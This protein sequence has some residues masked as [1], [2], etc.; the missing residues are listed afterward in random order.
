MKRIDINDK[1]Y[2]NPI[3]LYFSRL[4][5][6]YISKLSEEDKKI[7]ELELKLYLLLKG[8]LIVAASDLFTES[9]AE[10]FKDKEI[11]LEEGLIVPALRDKF[12]NIDDF[13]Q[14][15]YN[16]KFPYKSFFEN[17]VKF[18]LS[19]S[20][21]ENSNWF[22]DALYTNIL[23]DGS[24]LNRNLKLHNGKKRK[25]IE[26]IYLENYKDRGYEFYNF[27]LI[28]RAKN[29]LSKEEYDYFYKFARYIYYLSGARVVGGE[30]LIP[31][32]NLINEPIEKLQIDKDREY[33]FLQLSDI[34]IFIDLFTTA[35]IES[36][37]VDLKKIF[38]RQFI[39]N[40]SNQELKNTIFLIR[41]QIGKDVKILKE[42]IREFIIKFYL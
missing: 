18:V 4:D 35:F 2:L 38:N 21:E 25:I 7:V 39:E 22:R 16:G 17:N 37:Y 13:V 40:I 5:K 9:G 12:K 24:L 1:E 30:S 27:S 23:Y 36:L 10:F 32:R 3:R 41:A 42:K 6:N 11:F 8:Q 31:Q 20:L 14:E 33:P 15:K 26:E 19:W 34:D 28:E 29:V